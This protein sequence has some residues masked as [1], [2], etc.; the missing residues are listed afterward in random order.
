MDS[1]WNRLSCRHAVQ[2]IYVILNVL[3]PLTRYVN[4]IFPFIELPIHENTSLYPLESYGYILYRLIFDSQ[5]NYDVR[6]STS[7][8]ILYDLGIVG[9]AIVISS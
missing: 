1:R 5:L 2:R 6:V 7:S 4:R 8:V 3:L 9:L